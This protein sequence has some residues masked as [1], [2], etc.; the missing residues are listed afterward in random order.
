M[1]LLRLYLCSHD[2]T[3]NDETPRVPLRAVF[4]SRRRVER[5]IDG[6]A[7]CQRIVKVSAQE[8]KEG[9]LMRMRD[10]DN[11]DPRILRNSSYRIV[12]GGTLIRRMCE[13]RRCCE[14]LRLRPAPSASL[15][16]S[17]CTRFLLTVASAFSHARYHPHVHVTQR[18]LVGSHHRANVPRAISFIA[19]A[20]VKRCSHAKDSSMNRP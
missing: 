20:R 7:I 3:L 5:G 18:T 15:A 4:M 19:T 10:K 17:W 12:V 11:R 6:G 2:F 14:R 8:K 13:R 16:H 1:P 9:S